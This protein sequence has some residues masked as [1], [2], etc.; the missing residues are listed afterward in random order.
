MKLPPSF[1][2]SPDVVSL[3]KQLLGKAL[4]THLD[5]QITGGLIIE[6]EAYAGIAD[7]ACHSYNDR[8]TPRTEVMY[9]PGGIAYVYL[10]YGIHC[11]LNCV[12]SHEGDPKGVMIRAIQPLWGLETM[13][14]RRNKKSLDKTLTSGPGA[15]TAA[16]GI[17]RA[18]NG[19]PLDSP[20]L[21]IE[22]TDLQINPDQIRALPRIGVDYAG[23]DA[24]LPYRFQIDPLK[25]TDRD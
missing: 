4:F 2:Q 5:G 22:E 16:L 15:L 25:Y 13:L 24:L 12:T 11:L 8:R 9:Q 1:Y 21:W 17:T 3:S 10:C 14:K 7:R 6:T 23:E 19:I 20:S 18:Q